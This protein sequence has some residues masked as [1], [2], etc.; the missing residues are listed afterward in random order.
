MYAICKLVADCS[1][2]SKSH[3]PSALAGVT[4]VKNVNF[5]STKNKRYFLGS[6][7]SSDHD[8]E[9]ELMVHFNKYSVCMCVCDGHDGS[10]AVKFVKRYINEQVFDK[11]AWNALYN[12]V[13]Q[14]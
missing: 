11:P 4:N 3:P 8:N 12:K 7:T 14:T 5:G 6:Q 2:N 10:H 9:D 1:E 13:K